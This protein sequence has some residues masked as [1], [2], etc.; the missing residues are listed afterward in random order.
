[1]RQNIPCAESVKR[2]IRLQVHLS[3]YY[4]TTY[5]DEWQAVAPCCW[6]NKP[7]LCISYHV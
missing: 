4:K 7:S 1:M 5:Q 3:V 2:E 6:F